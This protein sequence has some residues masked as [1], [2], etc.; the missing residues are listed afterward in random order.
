MNYTLICDG[1]YSSS[2]DQG[3]VGIIFLRGEEKI[4]EYSKMFNIL[5]IKNYIA[6]R[7][8]GNLSYTRLLNSIP[9]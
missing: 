3:G 2:K 4:L 8:D 9:T 5:K 6:P 7:G 1:A